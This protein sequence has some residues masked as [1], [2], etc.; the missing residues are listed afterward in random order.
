M[1]LK[2]GVWILMMCKAFIRD[3]AEQFVLFLSVCK[4]RWLVIPRGAFLVKNF[5]SEQRT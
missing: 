5:I 4:E 3:S 1:A 2:H